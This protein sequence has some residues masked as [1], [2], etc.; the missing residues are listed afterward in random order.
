MPVL[1]MLGARRLGVD[2]YRLTPDTWKE[3]KSFRHNCPQ[4]SGPDKRLSRL[5]LSWERG[6]MG[7]LIGRNDDTDKK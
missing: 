5:F 4:R 1:H 2:N 6:R 7:R 3:I